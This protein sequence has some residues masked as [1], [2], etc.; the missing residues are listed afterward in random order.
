VSRLSD[1]SST[2]VTHHGFVG[3]KPPS[4]FFSSRKRY[5]SAD[6]VIA[7]PARAT[8]WVTA[9]SDESASREALRT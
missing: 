5:F 2:N 6:E 3:R 1:T 4:Q 9:G 7:A 8:S